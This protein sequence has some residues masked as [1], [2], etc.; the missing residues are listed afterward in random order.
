MG[1]DVLAASKENAAR[2]RAALVIPPRHDHARL[3]FRLVLDAGILH[4]PRASAPPGAP[5]ARELHARRSAGAGPRRPRGDPP[6]RPQSRAPSRAAPAR[7]AVV[8]P[9]LGHYLFMAHSFALVGNH[10][11]AAAPIT[12]RSTTNWRA[13]WI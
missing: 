4:L 12:K 7:R 10:S 13:D 5:S 3:A 9:H 1:Q 8:A 6:P 11:Q 2:R